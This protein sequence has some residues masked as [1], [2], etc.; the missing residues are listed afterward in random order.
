MISREITEI[1]KSFSVLDAVFEVGL[2]GLVGYETGQLA[3]LTPFV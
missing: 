2:I 3:P 1:I